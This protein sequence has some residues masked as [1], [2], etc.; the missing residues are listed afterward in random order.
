M[1][2]VALLAPA[3]RWNSERHLGAAAESTQGREQDPVS[4]GDSS[5]CLGCGRTELQDP[6][7]CSEQARSGGGGGAG[8][9]SYWVSC[10]GGGGIRQLLGY[11]LQPA[12]GVAVLAYPGTVLKESF[13]TLLVYL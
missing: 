11:L 7:S 1:T 2:I 6:W 5:Y 10:G 8:L 12:G 4:L 3:V 13:F 9:D